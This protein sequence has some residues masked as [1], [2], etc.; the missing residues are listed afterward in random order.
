MFWVNFTF[1]SGQKKISRIG[2]D[3]ITIR[4]GVMIL[5]PLPDTVRAKDVTTRQGLSVLQV[6]LA[7][8]ALDGAFRGGDDSR[9]DDVGDLVG[10]QGLS[11]AVHHCRRC[12]CDHYLLVPGLHFDVTSDI[13]FVKDEPL[14]VRASA[15][16]CKVHG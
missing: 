14:L 13:E 5:Q 15:Y 12:V 6:V 3:C 7:D 2:Y 10:V 4:A 1:G 11:D 8:S 16:K 9:R